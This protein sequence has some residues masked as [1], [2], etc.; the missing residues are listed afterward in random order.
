MRIS[1]TWHIWIWASHT[2][3]AQRPHLARGSHTGPRAFQDSGRVS[4]R[5]GKTGHPHHNHFT[6][7]QWDC[8]DVGRGTMLG[9]DRS[10]RTRKWRVA[11]KW[12]PWF[13]RLRP[14]I[15]MSTDDES[16]HGHGDR[17]KQPET[18][19]AVNST[20]DIH[21]VTCQ[22]QSKKDFN[23]R[24]GSSRAFSSPKEKKKK[25]I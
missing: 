18:H 5:K 9:Q 15:Q 14:A 11:Q 13:L 6:C 22:D 25:R 20:A 10:L 17:R 3:R 7:L 23:H 12:S 4:E 8:W 19:T 16:A 1:H 24:E 2:S 21:S